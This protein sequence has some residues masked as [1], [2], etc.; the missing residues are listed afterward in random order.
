M[1]LYTAPNDK[2]KEVLRKTVS[3]ARA[4]V[5]KKQAEANVCMTE[6]IIQE[7]LM[8]LKG[9]VTIVYP[10]DLP[11]FDPIRLEFEGKGDLSGT[12]V[13]FWW[14][15]C[16]SISDMSPTGFLGGVGR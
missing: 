13:S 10:M 11:P 9:A 1:W 6:E 8:K 2:M 16:V 4:A 3:E 14:L 5:S 7:A 12:Q 15:C